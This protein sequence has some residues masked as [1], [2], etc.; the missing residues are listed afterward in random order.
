MSKN[1]EAG[2]T[3]KRW[4]QGRACRLKCRCPSSPSEDSQS[5]RAT[6]NVITQF[7]YYQYSYTE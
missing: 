7:Q 4:V 1:K 5:I 2:Q 3:L 6:L